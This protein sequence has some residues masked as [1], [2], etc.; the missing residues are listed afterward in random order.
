MFLDLVGAWRSLV[1]AA[2]FV[3]T[4]IPER[5]VSLGNKCDSIDDPNSV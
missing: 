1:G 4:K 2:E 5:L 3:D